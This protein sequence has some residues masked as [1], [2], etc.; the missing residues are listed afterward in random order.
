MPRL[1]KDGQFVQNNWITL[2]TADACESADL[3][4]GYWV[5]PLQ[6]FIQQ[7]STEASQSGN[8]GLWV[9]GETSASEL[10]PVLHRTPL[11]CI[12]FP[13]FTDGRGFSLAR[14]LREHHDYSGEIRA[15]GAFIQDQLHYLKRCGFSSFEV[16]DNADL[17]S[18]NQ[19]LSDFSVSY[20]AAIDEPQPLFRRRNF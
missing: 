13:V 17:A 4:T 14:S 5:L 11:V 20:Q 3:S 6:Q 16:D 19:S 10:A 9:S 2:K 18:I 8:Y 12:D 15:T 7:L 1:I